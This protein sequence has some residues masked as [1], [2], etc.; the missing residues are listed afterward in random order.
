M[1]GSSRNISELLR[2]HTYAAVDDRGEAVNI[3]YGQIPT[4]A[5]LLQLA[6]RGFVTDHYRT[7]VAQ[8]LQDDPPETLPGAYRE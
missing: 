3:V 2:L 7:A 5:V 8:R 4:Y 1:H 6:P